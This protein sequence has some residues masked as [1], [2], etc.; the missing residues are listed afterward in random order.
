MIFVEILAI[1][2]LVGIGISSLVTLGFLVWM[3]RGGPFR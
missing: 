2:I 3:L 1:V